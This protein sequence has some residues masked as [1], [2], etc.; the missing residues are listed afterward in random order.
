M[1]LD[2]IINFWSEESRRTAGGKTNGIVFI[3]FSFYVFPTYFTIEIFNFKF[4][5]DRRPKDQ[6]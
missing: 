5:F 2:R 6:R 1:K 3:L 4:D